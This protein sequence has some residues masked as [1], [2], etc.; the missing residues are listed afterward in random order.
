[1]GSKLVPTS[2]TE[3]F[4]EQSRWTP[5][6]GTIDHT[7]FE[8]LIRNEF[9]PAARLAELQDQAALSML[10]FATAM[11]PYYRDVIRRENIDI[12]GLK[13]LAD[14]PR[15]PILTKQIQHREFRRLHAERLPWGE[16]QGGYAES[17]GTSG[18]PTKI[19][20]TYR[21][22]LLFAVFK[23]REMRWFRF[24]PSG[25][26][27]WVRFRGD[28]P[29][30]ADGRRIRPGETFRDPAWPSAGVFFET[31]PFIAFDKTNPPDDCAA[32]LE[33]NR[34][35]Y[36]TAAAA[37][38]EHLALAYQGR[39]PPDYLKGAVAISE[40]LTPGMKARVESIFGASLFQNY[41]QN[42]VGLV[43]A[44]CPEGGRYHTHAEQAFVEI[45]DD[46]GMP[47]APGE[48]G[49]V[50]VTD[51]NN[52]AMPLIRYDTGDLA[53]AVDGPC[54]CGRTIG[55]M[56]ADPVRRR[57]RVAP[58]PHGSDVLIDGLRGAMDTLPK[59]LA[60]PLRAYRIHQDKDENYRL[61]VVLKDLDEIPFEDHVRAA[62]AKLA[63]SA[64]H[65]LSFQVFDT[66]PI[67]RNGKFMHVTSEFIAPD[68]GAIGA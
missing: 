55:P 29:A 51:F 46:D 5:R 15:L 45:V 8:N 11:V 21:T 62:W 18:A 37:M 52:Y 33:D 66:I 58:L 4:E 20:R 12:G 16:Q 2:L 54:A 49:R 7:A 38:Q 6:P 24:D 43:A 10:R 28:I 65:A 59:D 40:T 57:A 23:Q 30:R 14:W 47:V 50:L 32:W 26:M 39:K 31:G 1:M 35:D 17:S 41:G 60:L 44:K 48:A 25:T 42:E 9:L 61:D 56:F 27:A 53:A 22:R 13:G 68:D 3:E 36:L 64:G 34:P 19:A 63:G 67:L